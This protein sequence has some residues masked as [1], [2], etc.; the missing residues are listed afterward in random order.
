[1]LNLFSK[2]RSTSHV[3]YI[4]LHVLKCRHVCLLVHTY[5]YHDCHLYLKQQKI[6]FPTNNKICCMDNYVYALNTIHKFHPTD[7]NMQNH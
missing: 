7:D 2:Q 1:M 5:H 6:S 3:V 4:I